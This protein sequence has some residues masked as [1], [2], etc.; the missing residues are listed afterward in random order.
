MKVCIFSKDSASALAVQVR[1]LIRAMGHQALARNQGPM[2]IHDVEHDAQV[3]MIERD[4]SESDE[5]ADKIE[6]LYREVEPKIAR[7]GQP[8]GEFKFVFLDFP[9]EGSDL[10]AWVVEHFA[11]KPAEPVDVSEVAPKKKG[12]SQKAEE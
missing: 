11:P 10:Y 6:S 2:S 8:A 12:K 4:G 1:G 3:V 9:A 7:I 5:T